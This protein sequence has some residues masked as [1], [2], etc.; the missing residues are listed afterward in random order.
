MADPNAE[1]ADPRAG[2]DDA[3]A[4]R[5]A[6]GAIAEGFLAAVRTALAAGDAPALAVLA[7]DLHEAD[8]ADLIAA[9]NADERVPFVRLMGERL[10]FTALTELDESLRVAILRALPPEFVA[11]GLTRIESDDAVY[12]LEDLSEAQKNAIL[13]R[14]PHLARMRVS[15][16]LDYPDET[17][18]RRMQTEFLAVPGFWTVGQTIDTIREDNDL[19]EEF[20]EVFVVDPAY[21]LIGTVALDRLLRARRGARMREVMRENQFTVRATED[22]EEVAQLFKRYNL[23]SV[24]VVDDAAR[25]VG[26][27]TIDDIVDVIEQE[28]EED[29][30]ALGGV[31]DE[32]MSDSVFYAARSRFPW[33]FVNMFT[34]FLSASVIA[35][36]DETISHMVAL[37]VL[38]PIVA[39]LGGNSGTQAMTVTVRALA[40]RELSRHN[41]L[42]VLGREML[43]ALMNGA[44]M[45]LIVGAVASLWFTNHEVGL[46]IAAALVANVLTAGFVGVVIP[47]A[48]S[49]VRIDPAVASGVLL[50]AITDMVGFSAFL[51]LSTWWF[52]LAA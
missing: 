25:L 43:V 36:F 50:T 32:E 13:A 41:A 14:L 38:M 8:L 20:Y 15:R 11:E 18:G 51:G 5:E 4:F 44:V 42:R 17:A 3:P 6:A 39:S 30:R 34:A 16:S 21:R 1:G 23:M 47:L 27:L 52:A 26:M 10:D 28:A 7:G 2:T 37:A 33:L 12:I 35:I 29:I 40:M 9:L 48:L 31:G 19:P 45:A 22:Q 49:A 24:A 46:V